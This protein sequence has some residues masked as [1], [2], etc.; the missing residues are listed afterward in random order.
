MTLLACPLIRRAACAAIALV[1]LAG[2]SLPAR[3]QFETR[4]TESVSG[5]SFDLAVGDFNHDGILDVAIPAG[6]SLFI[7]LGN[8]DGTFR[9]FV[10]YT[11]DFYSIVAAD[12]NND[13]NLDL[14]VA[15]FSNTVE[16]FLGNGDGTFQPPI[17]NNSFAGPGWLALGDFN[18]DHLLDVVVVGSFGGSQNVGVLLG[19]G[20]GTL[21]TPITQALL[22]PP[23]SVAAAD[24][25]R[26]GDLDVAIGNYFNDGL[27][28]LLGEGN[29]SFRDPQNYSGGGGAPV[30]I[31]DFSGDGN[32][33]LVATSSS[34][35]GAAEFLGNGD[36]TF[37]PARTYASNH[38]APWAAGDLNGD[39]KLDLVLRGNLPEAVT[40]MLNTGVLSFSPSSPLSFP[41]QLINT[42]SSP[43]TVQLT[44]TGSAEVSISSIT[45][46]GSFRTSNSCGNSVPPGGNCNVSVTFEPTSQGQHSGAVT[47]VDSASSKA[48]V[49]ELGGT[50]TVAQ[51]LPG[52]L[53][54]GEQKVGT[55]STPQVV[56][57]TN[58]GSMAMT[59]SSV[60][61]AGANPRDF[62]QTNSCLSGAVPPGGTCSVSVTF[63]PKKT[64]SRTGTLCINVEGGFSPRPAML[65]GRGD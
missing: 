30:I 24:F 42:S 38:G 54:F 10:S 9:Q 11:G 13:G 22:Y 40:S 28:V 58:E 14:L 45:A 52:S 3:A 48:Q 18:N 37:Q 27:T 5:E 29:G 12:F 16:V 8:G 47:L 57:V 49:V 53:K 25:N 2:V 51:V 34:G 20:N 19:N 65:A 17:D 36:G 46:S 44:N 63:A 23:G 41:S 59:F 56:T 31:G 35:L 33:D 26:D 4:A 7:L 64:G 55:Q 32:V 39:H 62:S 6:N 60:N 50:A 21:Q 1:W 61:I 15:P 43:Q